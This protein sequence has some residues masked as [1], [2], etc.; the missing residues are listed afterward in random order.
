MKRLSLRVKLL[1]VTLLSALPAT[2][3]AAGG[4]Y[5]A[6]SFA[7]KE[8]EARLVDL[9]KRVA[10]YQEEDLNLFL[11]LRDLLLTDPLTPL[12][13]PQ[14][15]R[16]MLRGADVRTGTNFQF[17]VFNED[18]LLLCT[19]GGSVTNELLEKIAKVR[20]TTPTITTDETAMQVYVSRQEILYISNLVQNGREFE[21]IGFHDKSNDNYTSELDDFAPSTRV[22]L[23]N[24][25]TLEEG[26]LT[27]DQAGWLPAETGLA[28]IVEAK[29]V[30]MPSFSGSRYIYYKKPAD[31]L[32]LVTLIGA[33][34]VE[35]EGG[36][37]ALLLAAL[38]SPFV[39]LGIMLMT[40]WL[41]VNHLIMR[42][43]KR[44]EG[45][46]R[47]YGKGNE[48][49]RVS[50][51]DNVPEEIATL[52]EAFNNMADNVSR[53]TNETRLALAGR[54]AILNDFHHHV[55]NNFQVIASLMALESRR[56]D[57][58]GAAI[59]QHQHDRVQAMAAAYKA[60]FARGEGANVS[61]NALFDDVSRLL[62]ASFRMNNRQCLVVPL[63]EDTEITLERAA[64][65]ALLVTDL[66]WQ[67]FSAQPVAAKEQAGKLILEMEMSADDAGNI[68]LIIRRYD[69]PLRTPDDFGV[70]LQHGYLTQIEAILDRRGI[71]G[72]GTE[73]IITFKRS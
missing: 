13:N 67:S 68:L 21:L 12:N 5:L 30:L 18:N 26:S 1:L 4:L 45:V 58:A 32:P 53:R 65:L 73:I 9:G 20:E 44:L 55:K 71:A 49:A 10:M 33:R 40:G 57:P 16:A 72:G 42:W 69:A 14:I 17:L 48:K 27:V 15:C 29:P 23:Y 19:A 46:T 7:M 38:I 63:F 64:P 2:L 25:E 39:L 31:N 3:I 34:F 59:L 50:F 11:G 66:V 62:R 36:L 35:I 54:A 41:S 8:K 28:D 70:A 43:I 22:L 47:E 51:P 56:K 61:L 37:N 24:P 60:A 52:G 6:Q